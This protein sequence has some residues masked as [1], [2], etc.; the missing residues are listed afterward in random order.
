MKINEECIACGICIDEC[1]NDTISVDD[2]IYVID[3]DLCTECVGF[4]DTPQCQEVFPVEAIEPD[5]EHRE[6]REALLEKKK[7]SMVNKTN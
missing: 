6:S 5:P 7:A 2:P 1:P 3:P 4:Y